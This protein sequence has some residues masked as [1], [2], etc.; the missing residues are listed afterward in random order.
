MLIRN[1][2]KWYKTIKEEYEQDVEY[3]LTDP[4]KYVIIISIEEEPFEEHITHA[5]VIE[6]KNTN[7]AKQTEKQV[8]E[9]LEA[10]HKSERITSQV[11][12]IET[13]QE[14]EKACLTKSN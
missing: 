4:E 11:K 3:Y 6:A 10:I 12:K 13:L 14:I 2:D 5:I 1:F 7:D 8:V 9:A